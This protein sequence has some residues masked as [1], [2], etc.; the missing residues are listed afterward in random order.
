MLTIEEWRSIVYHGKLCF[1][2]TN[3][4]PPGG[5]PPP[6]NKGTQAGQNNTSKPPPNN[7]SPPNNKGTQAGQNST[8]AP[9]PLGHT[10][11]LVRPGSGRS[12]VVVT[13]NEPITRNSFA[14]FNGKC[15]LWTL[16]QSIQK[17]TRGVFPPADVKLQYGWHNK[18]T[19]E[20][21]GA[22]HI[23]ARHGAY[24]KSLNLTAEQYVYEIVTNATKVY[25][26]AGGVLLVVNDIFFQNLVVIAL[27][28]DSGQNFY[29][30]ITGYQNSPQGSSL[31]WRR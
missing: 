28:K 14:Y 2:S 5:K 21:S 16:P 3:K 4:P 6:S 27:K 25:E 12:S 31:V 9:K 30:V 29:K 11:G 1:D 23:T 8:N 26:S 20:G 7:N 19:G 17:A 13:Y 18:E 10:S 22:V 24:L 15:E